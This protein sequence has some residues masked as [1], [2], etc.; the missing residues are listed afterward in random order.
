MGKSSSMASEIL[1]SLA[2]TLE[3]DEDQRKELIDSIKVWVSQRENTR[4][5]KIFLSLLACGGVGIRETS[6]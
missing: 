2:K 4:E 6:L 5:R 3:K 1:E